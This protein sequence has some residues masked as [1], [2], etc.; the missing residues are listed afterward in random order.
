MITVLQRTSGKRAPAQA[1]VALCFAV[2]AGSSM[3]AAT[4]PAT[5][6]RGPRSLIFASDYGAYALWCCRVGN[7]AA[8]GASCPALLARNRCRACLRA[9]RCAHPRNPFVFGLGIPIMGQLLVTRSEYWLF[10]SANA[11]RVHQARPWLLPCRTL[12]RHP[13]NLKYYSDFASS[14]G[15]LSYCVVKLSGCS[16]RIIPFAGTCGCCVGPPPAGFSCAS[17][18]RAS[19]ANA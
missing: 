7:L 11:M 5:R 18:A 14:G 12:T 16:S 4:D 3:Q 8:R 19:Q 2:R 9:R 15:G 6:S 17:T 13:L 1:H 10:C